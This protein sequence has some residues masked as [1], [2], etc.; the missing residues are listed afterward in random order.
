MGDLRWGGTLNIYEFGLT[1]DLEKKLQR[2]TKGAMEG[3]SF[4]RRDCQERDA[5]S[6][7]E[8]ED[9]IGLKT[10]FFILILRANLFSR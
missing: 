6:G 1:G 7:K 4:F 3:R 2:I 9:A 5:F 8:S 10:R